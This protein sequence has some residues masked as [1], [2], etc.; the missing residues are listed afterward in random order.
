MQVAVDVTDNIFEE[1]TWRRQT[2]NRKGQA[3]LCSLLPNHNVWFSRVK[4]TSFY[5]SG[6]KG[7]FLHIPLLF[8]DGPLDLVGGGCFFKKKKY[9]HKDNVRKK[10][11]HASAYHSQK[12]YL[13][14]NEANLHNI[15]E[16]R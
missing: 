12:K 3:V 2:W 15:C 5:M 10:K 14:G 1:L 16:Y 7:W 9:M 6:K 4:H 8:R 13:Q 11:K